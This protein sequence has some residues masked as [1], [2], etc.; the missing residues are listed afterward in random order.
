VTPKTSPMAAH[1]YK[2]MRVVSVVGART[3]F[4][5]IAA[6]LAEPRGVPD[7]E[8]FLMHANSVADSRARTATFFQLCTSANA[9]RCLEPLG[10]LDLLCL[11]DT[12][13]SG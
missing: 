13:G 11:V 9:L 8:R 5:K 10:Y 6:V 1:V 4:T 12:L 2:C 3:N 7:I